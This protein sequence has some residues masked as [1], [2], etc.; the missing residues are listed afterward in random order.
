MFL[1]I[2]EKDVPEE[3]RAVFKDI[4]A[5]LQN[6]EGKESKDQVGE[7][8]EKILNFYSDLLMY[9]GEHNIRF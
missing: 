8:A 9:M 4:Y 5:F 1:E 3:H 7:C 6:M 2:N